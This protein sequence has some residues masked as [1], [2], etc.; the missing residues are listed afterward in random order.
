[1]E[2]LGSEPTIISLP[3]NVPLHLLPLDV[4][5]WIYGT[6]K[7]S[8]ISLFLQLYLSVYLF[9]HCYGTNQE[10]RENMTL[11]IG[12]G[13]LVPHSRILPNPTPTSLPPEAFLT[14]HLP[15]LNTCSWGHTEHHLSMFSSG[16]A[17]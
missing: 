14:H 10:K 1:M 7:S 8:C 3:H 2:D 15:V 16:F 4:I 17:T 13:R 9:I 5:I 12:Q 11:Q 6:T